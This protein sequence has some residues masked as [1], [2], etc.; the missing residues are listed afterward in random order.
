[1]WRTFFCAIVGCV[2]LGYLD[3]KQAGTLFLFD[4][5]FDRPWLWFEVREFCLL[6]CVCFHVC[7]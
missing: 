2:T 6:P 3:P 4:V 7:F 1:M 5:R